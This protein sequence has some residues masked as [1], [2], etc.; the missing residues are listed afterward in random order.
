MKPSFTH[1]LVLCLFF[2]LYIQSMSVHA[3]S[4]PAFFIPN[5]TYLLSK[6]YIETR[7]CPDGQGRIAPGTVVDMRDCGPY[8]PKS[9]NWI[10]KSDGMCRDLSTGFKLM[11]YNIIHHPDPHNDDDANT[12]YSVVTARYGENNEEESS[13]ELVFT[14]PKEHWYCI[15]MNPELHIITCAND[16]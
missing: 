16:M 13:M 6:N 10:A 8:C 5:D 11:D 12:L 4:W 15:V 2:L 9:W 14:T 1:T 7:D 3:N